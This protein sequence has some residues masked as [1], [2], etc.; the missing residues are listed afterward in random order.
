MF[1]ASLRLL[2]CL[3]HIILLYRH[4]FTLDLVMHN[5][6]QGF[7][8]SSS[9]SYVCKVHRPVWNLTSLYCNGS[10]RCLAAFFRPVDFYFGYVKLIQSSCQGCYWPCYSS[11]R[12]SRSVTCLHSPYQRC[13]GER[14]RAISRVAVLHQSPWRWPWSLWWSSAGARSGGSRASCETRGEE[15]ETCPTRQK[16]AETTTHTVFLVHAV[17]PRCRSKR[18]GS[19][20]QQQTDTRRR[21]TEMELDGQ[22]RE[23]SEFTP[24]CK[25]SGR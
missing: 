23:R 24:S 6:K 18:D 2:S 3:V 25:G 20:I 12:R 21:D 15:K 5:V 1:T 8:L 16:C 13:S 9:P 14:D 11:I 17:R 10:C 7:A 19:R 22:R 4:G